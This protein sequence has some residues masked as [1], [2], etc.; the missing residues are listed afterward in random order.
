VQ[1]SAITNLRRAG[2]WHHSDS[3]FRVRI[4][5]LWIVFSLEIG[6]ATITIRR[7]SDIADNPWL[8][9]PSADQKL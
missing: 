6:S 1:C 9:L 3:K 4:R 2:F 5:H 8:S 7:R